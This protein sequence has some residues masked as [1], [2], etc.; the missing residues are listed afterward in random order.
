[1]PDEMDLS[2][3]SALVTG[4]GR[5]L[6][7][8]FAEALAARGAAVAAHYGESAEGAAEVVRAAQ[9]RGT[10]AVALQAD[11]ADPRQ[12]A[13]L[14]D[15]AAEAL[16]FVDVL[17]NSASVFDPG[18]PL[19]TDLGAWERALRVNLTAPFLLSQAFA[20][21][22]ARD[23][24]VIVN[25]LDWR[26]LRPAADHFAYT[27]SKAGLAS[28]TKSLA[29]SLAPS[30]RVNGLAL[31]A[32]LP[33]AGQGI[34]PDRVVERVPAGRWGTVEEAVQALLFLI[35]G[36]GFVTG[37]ILHLDGGRHIG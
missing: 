24:G 5:R 19:E 26:A 16:G 30:I 31:G 12:T 17:V 23:P 25:L 33:P 32:I 27:I 37:A 4:A 18:G 29:L 21:R 8:A 1:M 34:G 2:G 14:V 11:L 35:E 7:R 22:R 3:R 13:A 15:R 36:S 9:E 20:R 28:M 6:G 10:P